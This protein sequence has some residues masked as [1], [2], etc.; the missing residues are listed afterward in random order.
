MHM[1]TNP[2]MPSGKLLNLR[3]EGLREKRRTYGW[4]RDRVVEEE[5]KGPEAGDQQFQQRGI[6]EDPVDTASSR[7]EATGNNFLT[8]SL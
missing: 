5:G 6:F 1:E 7:L 3:Q 8:R 2:T 4:P